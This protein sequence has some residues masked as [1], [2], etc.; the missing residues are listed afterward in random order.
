M[1]DRV[2]VRLFGF[3]RTLRVPF[4]GEI[5]FL[6]FA[7]AFSAGFTAKIVKDLVV[8]DVSHKSYDPHGYTDPKSG[9][10]KSV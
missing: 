10:R 3:C 4:G 9:R 1:W 6:A 5:L 2:V 7:F 8:D